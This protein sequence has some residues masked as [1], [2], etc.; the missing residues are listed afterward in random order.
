MI[1]VKSVGQ[2]QTEERKSA[3][4]KEAAS[5]DQSMLIS[6]LA[7]YLDILWEKAKR[8][9]QKPERQ[10]LK[11]LRARQGKYSQK[12]LQAMRVM[13]GA[14]Y[15]PP[16]MNITETKCRAAEAWI[17]DTVFVPGERAWSLEPTPLPELPTAIMETTRAEI[18]NALLGE[19]QNMAMTTG[20][21]PDFNM[22]SQMMEDLAPEMEKKIKKA[23]QDK[24]NEAAEAMS[25]K[26]AD[27]FQEG[28]WNEELEKAMY[29]CTTYGTM[30]LKGPLPK[31]SPIR[32][33]S[34]D[35]ETGATTISLD[36]RISPMWERRSPLRI[37]PLPDTTD[38]NNGGLFDLISMTRKNLSDLIGIEGYNERAIRKVLK[39]HRDG[40][41]RE[42]T[43]IDTERLEL[44]NRD[45]MTVFETENIDCLEYHGSAPGSLLKE[46]GMSEDDVPD[47]EKEY[48]VVIWKISKWV[49][50]AMLNPDMMGR[51]YFF[52]AG[53][54]ANPDSFW[55]KGIPEL[56][57]SIQQIANSAARAIVQNVAIASGPMVEV[58]MDRL[59][60][61]ATASIHP[62]KVYKTNNQ[63]MQEGKA[64]N[65]YAP[66]IVVNRLMEVYEFCLKQADEDSGVPRYAHG[67]TQVGGAGD[68]A[69]GLSMLI[70]Q[71]SRGIK[72]V[73]KNIDKAISASV[74]MIFD[75]NMANDPSVDII[76]DM[77]AV[78]KGASALMA[79]EQQTVRRKEILA[80][81]NNP[82]DLQ[83]IGLRGRAELLRENVKAL[84][85]DP[86]KIVQDIEDIEAQQAELARQ[87]QEALAA[88]QA[89]AGPAGVTA[90]GGGPKQT[91]GAPLPKTKATDAAG[92]PVAG[93]DNQMFM[94]AKGTTP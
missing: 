30:V 39:A 18:L 54:S 45:T 67:E 26:I 4:A 7:S 38:V 74:Q 47:D 12:K 24:A 29:D 55:D 83:I 41:L 33:P 19:V 86:D 13:F 50:K 89:A 88:E 36:E 27:Q 58:N 82:V 20:Q 14:D 61:G 72:S 22:L 8:A 69:S 79:K 60:P 73:I 43:T 94:S 5:V 2:I 63:G 80:E 11:N 35:E 44:Q 1:E 31:R 90:G 65:F 56:I 49:I 28:G 91:P 53:F 92:S 40:G 6:N 46:Y 62:W 77:K 81:T 84:D 87:E 68:T 42:W 21:V 75:Y 9:K 37:Y 32:V 59:A 85:M 71:A 48:D 93:R 15:E 10:M 34:F 52:K 70:S 3:E 66:P 64:V 25:E 51:K 76:G 23:V 78:A 17:K 16:Y 57:D